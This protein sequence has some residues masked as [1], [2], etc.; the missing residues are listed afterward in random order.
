MGL[1]PGEFAICERR[2]DCILANDKKVP[3]RAGSAEFLYYNNSLRARPLRSRIIGASSRLA[4]L[5]RLRVWASAATGHAGSNERRASI[6]PQAQDLR[7][8]F[9]WNVAHYL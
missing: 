9:A 6:Q 1:V 3:D 8:G 7:G 4:Q 5:V 2:F